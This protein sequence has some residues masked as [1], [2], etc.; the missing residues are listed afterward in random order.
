MTSQL[1]SHQ[2]THD[3][4]EI[5]DGDLRHECAIFLA[6]RRPNAVEQDASVLPFVLNGLKIQS[7]RGQEGFGLAC[8][9][10]SAKDEF[11]ILR[12]DRSVSD[13]DKLSDE[14]KSSMFE[15]FEQNPIIGH[16]RYATHGPPDALNSQPMQN[17]HAGAADPALH[18]VI[19]FNGHIANADELRAEIESAGYYV[20]GSTDTEVLLQLITKINCE[21][22]VAG[23]ATNYG[24]IFSKVDAALDGACSMVLLDGSGDA[25]LYRHRN[26]IRPLELFESDDGIILAASET[27][28]FSGLTGQHRTI[29]PG[30]IFHYHKSSDSWSISR[31]GKIKTRYCIMELLYFGRANSHYKGVSHYRIRRDIGGLMAENI[32]ERFDGI[33]SYERSRIRI[34][35]VPNTAIPFA[36][37]IANALD[38]P[39]EMGIERRENIRAFIN[40]SQDRR[41]EILQ[42]K[43][44]ILTEAVAG[45]IVV[46][47]DDTLIRRDTSITITRMLR[48]AGA[49]RVD[50]LICAPPF[51]GTC[52]YGIA[53]PSVDELAY[54]SAAKR[55]PQEIRDRALTGEHV[56]EIEAEIA[57]DIGMDSLS[58]LP[59]EML[60][61]ALP[62]DG[63]QYCQGCFLGLYPT[64]K[65]TEKFTRSRDRFLGLPSKSAERAASR[66]IADGI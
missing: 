49:E 29:N 66:T 26:G 44:A 10:N 55:L 37:G 65:G 14:H 57:R 46:I 5:V 51:K 31:V 42:R 40:A 48:E 11:R 43:F 27:E 60:L 13:L 62:G 4:E 63:K 59:Y 38:L 45:K 20:R 50:W 52:Y 7:N 64:P 22:I 56:A 21:T 24:A 17:D 16:N 19:A 3:F 33:S 36:L 6:Y 28:A 25:V 35:P 9:G 61:K 34:I 32:R 30:E 47:V 39:Y 41:L 18:K 54:W 23:E 58:F 15:A 53:V 8:H 2:T 1:I 12:S